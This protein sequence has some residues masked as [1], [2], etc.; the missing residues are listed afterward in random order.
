MVYFQYIRDRPLLCVPDPHRLFDQTSH[1]ITPP[2]KVECGQSKGILIFSTRRPQVE[3]FLVG[4]RPVPHPVSTFPSQR[5]FYYVLLPRPAA[6]IGFGPRPA[7]HNTPPTQPR[8]T[9]KTIPT[10]S[11]AQPPPPPPLNPPKGPPPPT[12]PKQPT[13][14]PK[15][16][17]SVASLESR[18]A[19][20]A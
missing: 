3:V 5:P 1:K 15:S 18:E 8:A 16:G 12:P 7:L 11:L 2:I 13:P 10:H 4:G 6:W 9:P 20:C 14:P 19:D 17:K